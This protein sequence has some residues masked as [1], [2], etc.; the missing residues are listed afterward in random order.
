MCPFG[1][2]QVEI[3]R[4]GIDILKMKN[5]K[6]NESQ[7]WNDVHENI[8]LLLLSGNINVVMIVRFITATSAQLS[9][10]EILSC[11]YTVIHHSALF[12]QIH[13]ILEEFAITLFVYNIN[14]KANLQLCVGLKVNKLSVKIGLKCMNLIVNSLVVNLLSVVLRM[15][16]SGD[17]VTRVTHTDPTLSPLDN[18]HQHTGNTFTEQLLYFLIPSSYCFLSDSN[19]KHLNIPL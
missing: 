8:F 18:I 12:T 5:L 7:E 15:C 14:S 11:F 2:N 4:N 1:T 10:C 19:S 16:Q 6:S 13:H 9:H 17:N 3:L